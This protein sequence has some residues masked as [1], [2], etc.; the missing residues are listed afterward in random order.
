MPSQGGQSS[1]LFRM[2]SELQKRGCVE[3]KQARSLIPPPTLPHPCWLP[4]HNNNTR[5]K[6]GFKGSLRPW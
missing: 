2:F 1:E 6:Q 5:D 4:Q 3:E